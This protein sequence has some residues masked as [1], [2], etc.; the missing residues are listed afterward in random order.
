[1]PIVPWI[2][3][4][5]FHVMS[6]WK[7]QEVQQLKYMRIFLRVENNKTKDKSRWDW[8]GKSARKKWK[9]VLKICEWRMYHEGNEWFLFSFKGRKQ[10]ESGK[11]IE[12]HVW[13]CVCPKKVQGFKVRFFCLLPYTTHCSDTWLP[14]IVMWCMLYGSREN[15][16]NLQEDHFPVLNKWA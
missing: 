14:H 16:K 13:E 12:G 8:E 2:L 15:T 3:L 4:I 9:I 11:R 10:L 7:K 1:M 6:F 5:S